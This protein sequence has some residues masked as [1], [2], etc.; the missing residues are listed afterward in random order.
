MRP[1]KKG[2][3]SAHRSVI[4][5]S[6]KGEDLYANKLMNKQNAVCPMAYYSTIK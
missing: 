6:Q 4:H 3:C 2:V 5:D 1:Q